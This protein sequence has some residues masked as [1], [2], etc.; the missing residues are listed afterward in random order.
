MEYSDT[1]PDKVSRES[2]A[3]TMASSTRQGGGSHSSILQNWSFL[4]P[5][6]KPPLNSDRWPIS[7]RGCH[8]FQAVFGHATASEVGTGEKETRP[9]VHSSKGA[10]SLY[11][12]H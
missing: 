11:E 6:K 7:K 2:P 12:V 4:G 9:R 5:K 10:S 3:P 1:S 8:R